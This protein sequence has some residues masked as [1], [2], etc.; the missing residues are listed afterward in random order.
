MTA[1][2]SKQSAETTPATTEAAKP[3]QGPETGGA[4]FIPHK[5]ADTQTSSSESAPAAPLKAQDRKGLPAFVMGMLGGLCVAA[6]LAL[7]ALIL[8][9]LSD[10]NE[11]VSSVETTA[12]GAAT[13]RAVETNDKR[14]AALEAKLETMRTDLEALNRMPASGGSDLSALKS[15]LAQIDQAIATLQ[16]D[17]AKAAKPV[18]ATTLAQDAARLTL[19]LVISDKIEQGQAFAQEMQTLTALQ[20]DTALFPALKPWMEGAPSQA[21]LVQE[22]ARAYPAL[23]KAA[24]APADETVSQF[25]L[26]HLKQWVHWRRLDQTDP[27]DPESLL[28]LINLDLQKSQNEEALRRLRTLP[29]SMQPLANPLQNLLTQRIE[30]LKAADQLFKTAMGQL[31]RSAQNK[32]SAQ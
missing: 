5:T 21:A 26:R 8:N 6:L 27:S 10:L 18:L 4:D 3:V 30:A 11:R 15:Q 24:P 32:G 19:A 17:S 25:M 9:P 29:A 12:A 22:L 2:P 7:L 31:M 28:Q 1:S 14:L 16:Q 13:R 23:I 20:E